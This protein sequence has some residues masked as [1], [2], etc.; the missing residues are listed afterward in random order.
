MSEMITKNNKTVGEM[1]LRLDE[2][3]I[4]KDAIERDLREIANR[5]Q[6]KRRVGAC[7]SCKEPFVSVNNASLCQAC[8]K[9]I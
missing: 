3:A 9:R 8:E 1:L 5:M 4:E 7:I 6:Q 2:I